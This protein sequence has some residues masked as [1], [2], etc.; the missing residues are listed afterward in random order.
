MEPVEIPGIQNQISL[1]APL[2]EIENDIAKKKKKIAAGHF[3]KDPSTR[4]NFSKVI[5]IYRDHQKCP[6]S[7]CFAYLLDCR[8]SNMSPLGLI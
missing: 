1:K 2:P 5:P 4:N 7:L 3:C 8:L 6:M